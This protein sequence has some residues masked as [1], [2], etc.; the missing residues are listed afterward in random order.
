MP[1]RVKNAKIA[2]LDFNLTKTK[3]DMGVHVVV[4]FIFQIKM[5]FIIYLFIYLFILK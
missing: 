5:F 4:R 1:R 2:L 3:M